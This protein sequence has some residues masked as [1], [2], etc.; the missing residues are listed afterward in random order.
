MFYAFYRTFHTACCIYAVKPTRHSTKCVCVC[1]CGYHLTSF[2]NS[3]ISRYTS[4]IHNVESAFQQIIWYTLYIW[5]DTD[6]TNGQKYCPFFCNCFNPFHFNSFPNPPLLIL[7]PRP[8]R[9]TVLCI[10]WHTRTHL[11]IVLSSDNKSRAAILT[12]CIFPF[13]DCSV[14]FSLK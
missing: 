10:I 6:V 9:F 4:S 8:S 14:S 3:I 11:Y 5:Y 7:F 2:V 12:K 13:E 1:V